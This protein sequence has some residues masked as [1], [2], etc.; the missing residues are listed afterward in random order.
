MNQSGLPLE[1]MTTVP[2]PMNGATPGAVAVMSMS[3]SISLVSRGDDDTPLFRVHV[4][5]TPL[6]V[7]VTATVY[8]RPAWTKSLIWKPTLSLA[9]ISNSSSLVRGTRSRGWLEPSRI[10]CELTAQ[11]MVQVVVMGGFSRF[12]W[13]VMVV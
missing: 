3:S 11:V 13:L 12:E 1:R 7:E 9:T 5:T 6:R 4:C 8:W 2:P 10:C